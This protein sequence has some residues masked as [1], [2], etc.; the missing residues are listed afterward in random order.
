MC[1]YGKVSAA[2]QMPILS[3]M[4][5]DVFNLPP[6]SSATPSHTASTPFWNALRISRKPCRSGTNW[7]FTSMPS[8]RVSW[9]LAS[10]KLVARYCREQAAL[11]TDIYVDPVMGD[12]GKLYG[13]ASE[14]TVRCMKGDAER[15]ASLFSQ[16]YRGLAC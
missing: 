12:Y 10:G 5:L 2:V 3:Y 7:A 6:C 9:L 15:I 11:G 4:G 14:S 1:V 8:P 16:L 13:G